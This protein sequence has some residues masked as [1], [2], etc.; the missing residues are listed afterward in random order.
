LITRY[1]KSGDLTEET[2]SNILVNSALREKLSTPTSDSEKIEYIKEALLED[3]KKTQKILQEVKDRAKKLEGDQQVNQDKINELATR[4][5]NAQQQ[6]SDAE[7]KFLKEKED[8]EKL[9]NE[10]RAL[11]RQQQQTEE[12]NKLI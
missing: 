9:Q 10:L 8:K 12:S 7:E 4:E 6:R 5:A 1:E 11:L 3:H 2:I